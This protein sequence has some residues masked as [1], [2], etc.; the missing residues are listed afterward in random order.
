MTGAGSGA[1][2]LRLILAGLA[3]AIEIGRH[4]RLDRLRLNAETLQRASLAAAP[5]LTTLSCLS[6]ST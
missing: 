2:P 1:E 6:S 5:S 3:I 4:D